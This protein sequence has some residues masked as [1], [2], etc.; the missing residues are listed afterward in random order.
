MTVWVLHQALTPE[1]EAT[2][3]QRDRVVLPFA[4]LPDLSQV[5]D[6]WKLKEAIAALNPDWPPE[7]VSRLAERHWQLFEALQPED[8]IAVPL[9]ARQE[10]LLAEVSGKY[11]YQVGEDG[12]DVHTVQVTWYKQRVPLAKFGKHKAIFDV[13]G[14][15][16]YEVADIEARTAIRNHLPHGYVKFVR[17]K[18]LLIVFLI[19]EAI[20]FATRG[21][22]L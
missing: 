1:E 9:P 14:E 11:G 8:I 7:T 18:K 4:G 17:L 16:L 3:D 13:R 10:V 5:P 15:S 12:Q 19:F 2:L 21:I 20:F 6:F 22:H